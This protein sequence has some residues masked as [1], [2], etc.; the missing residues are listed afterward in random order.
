ML[1]KLQRALCRCL[2]AV[3]IDIE[4]EMS[5]LLELAKSVLLTNRIGIGGVFSSKRSRFLYYVD[6]LFLQYV[7]TKAH[8]VH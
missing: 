7:C 2:C 1:A 6:A 4:I 3:H 5:F 8:Y